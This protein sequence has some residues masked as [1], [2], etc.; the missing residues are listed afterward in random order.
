MESGPSRYCEFGAIPAGG[1][2]LPPPPRPRPLPPRPPRPEPPN[3]PGAG[4]CAKARIAAAVMARPV[5]KIFTLLM[6]RGA[7]VAFLSHDGITAKPDHVRRLRLHT[8]A[9]NR[10]DLG[11]NEIH[12]SLRTDHCY[13]L[14]WRCSIPSRCN[15]RRAFRR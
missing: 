4:G 15:C 8:L 9:L 5:P 1:G 14:V 10:L 12:A 13:E 2:T 3:A 7:P 11:E 6:I